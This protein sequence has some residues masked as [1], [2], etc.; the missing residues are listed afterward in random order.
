MNFI[1]FTFFY[2]TLAFI[3]FFLFVFPEESE[4]IINKIIGDIKK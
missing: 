4:N 2:W 1:S 3:L